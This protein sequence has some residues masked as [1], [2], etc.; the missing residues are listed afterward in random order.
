MKIEVEI[1]KI[2]KRNARV[3][4]D[5]AWETSL[6]RKITIAVLTYLVILSFFVVIKVQNPFTN[7]LVPTFGFL[8]STLSIGFFKNYWLKNIYKK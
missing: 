7:A 1:Q 2:K 3:E 6:F 4:V 8:L 5:K